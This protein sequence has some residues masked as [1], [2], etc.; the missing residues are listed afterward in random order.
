[1]RS[2]HLAHGPPAVLMPA[3]QVDLGALWFGW[4][5][6][7]VRYVVLDIPA[8]NIPRQRK[9]F[10]VV[11]QI[12]EQIVLDDRA[13]FGHGLM[14]LQVAF[15]TFRC[16]DAIDHLGH[17]FDLFLGQSIFDDQ[18]ALFVKEVQLLSRRTVL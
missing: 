12:Q 3:A 14:W 9:D 18:V 10:V 4:V 5:D 11:E 6:D 15:G 13:K 2:L 16:I 8:E 17:L 1:M 7:K